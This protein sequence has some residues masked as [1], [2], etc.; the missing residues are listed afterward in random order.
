[1]LGTGEQTM[2]LKRDEIIKALEC[3][4]SE[5]TIEFNCSECPYIRKGCNIAVMR[6]ALALIKELTEKNEKWQT[7][8]LKQED[9]MQM[10]AQEK[11]AIYDEL[12]TVKDENERLHASCT[13]LTRNL[14]ECKADT[15]RKMQERI[16]EHATNGFP[17]KIRLDVVDKIAKEIL[18]D[19]K[20]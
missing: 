13:E 9:T 2:K 17:R 6:D 4:T 8:A 14:H 5:V 1:M 10:I 3:C 16:A 18:E 15:V 12:V 11:Q 19:N 7:V 20:E